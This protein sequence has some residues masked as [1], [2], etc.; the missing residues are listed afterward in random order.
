MADN[1]TTIHELDQPLEIRQLRLE[2]VRGPA[3]GSFAI[4]GDR[5]IFLGRERG[6][7]FRLDDPK[8]SRRHA[9]VYLE[10]GRVKVEDLN[11]ANGTFLDGH[12]IDRGEL[13]PGAKLRIGAS[14]FVLRD[15]TRGIGGA[16]GPFER[17]GILGRSK[18]MQALEKTLGKFAQSELPVLLEGESGSG[19][20]ALALAVHRL[21][22]RAP[23][24][25][26]V[27]DCTLLS[28]EHLRSEL[29]GHVKGAFTGAEKD[30]AGAFVRAQGGTL[31]LDEIG[32]LPLD[33]QPQL[34]RVLESQEV[35]PLGA[36][37]AQKV[38]VRVVSAT[39]RNLAAKVQD[40]S[41][42]E[43][44]FYRLGALHARVP[45]L[46]ERLED[47]E[48]LARHFLGE[49][50]L[51]PD[52]LEALK[53]QPWPGNVRQLR[54]CLERAR[55]LSEGRS[56]TAQDLAFDSTPGTPLA[57][58]DTPLAPEAA[59]LQDLEV[60]AIQEAL[61][62]AGGNRK[63]AARRLGIARSTFYSKL[64]KLGLEPV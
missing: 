61:R 1:R 51:E 35:R 16:K 38:S 64:K 28:P 20:E 60:Q 40:K 37:S 5:P 6:L 44:L 29:F 22:P 48:V 50:A 25:Y 8:A 33:L 46:R 49:L 31:F 39:H 62:A 36:G 42:R 56:L 17:L 57:K 15:A 47:L 24:P 52:A 3:A 30:R 14:E 27:V 18:A 41:F 13:R 63:E 55:V 19:K 2:G 10:R 45:A 34:L 58:P 11:S 7:E 54:H 32:E 23:G 4:L 26:V 53:A 12:R 59:T 9:R 43:D 21:S